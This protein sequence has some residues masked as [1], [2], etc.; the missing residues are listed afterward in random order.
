VFE[1]AARPLYWLVEHRFTRTGNGEWSF[2]RVWPGECGPPLDFVDGRLPSCEN[3]LYRLTTVTLTGE[4]TAA[5]VACPAS[6]AATTSTAGGCALGAHG[7]AT[8]FA[9]VI[10]V[11]FV[12]LCLARRRRRARQR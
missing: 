12:S 4:T 11:A 8:S 5:E 10:A 9:A 1:T 3:T 2:P 6:P 7:G